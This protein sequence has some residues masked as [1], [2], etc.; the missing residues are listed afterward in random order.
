MGT[1]GRTTMLKTRVTDI[2]T[3]ADKHPFG[4]LATPLLGISVLYGG[5]AHLRRRLYALGTLKNRR[6]PCPVISVGNLTL[7]GTGKT[8]MVIH[9]AERILA[10]GYRP[11]I[12]SRG[13]KGLA[14]KRGAVV[15]DGRSLLCDAR[16]AGD[17]PYLMAALLPTVPVAVGRNRYRIGMDAVRRF[18]PDMVILD[19]GFQHLQLARDFNMLLLDARRPYGNGYIFPRGTLREPA[20]SLHSADAVV[21]TRSGQNRGGECSDLIRRVQPRP[22]F[23]S[24]HNSVV[25]LLLGAGQPIAG[26]TS[27]QRPDF[28]LKGK[29]VFA[30]TGLARNDAFFHALKGLGAGLQGTKGFDDH[31]AFT[32]GDLHRIAMDAER[33]GATCLV[34][35]DKD[36]VRLPRGIRLPLEL[37]VMG[38]RMDFGEQRKVWQTYIERVVK[39]LA[40]R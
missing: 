9:L 29:R 30:F 6:L 25:R 16:Q 8:P 3:R 5:L 12:L 13:Y 32:D 38:V 1:S 14:E 31:H 27:G 24:D 7:G 40:K 18:H 11:V 23:L 39:K 33:A 37:I 4:S 10:M 34:T 20:T 21:L 2:M 17:E 19:D 15:S 28:D 35:T 36:F 26:M 22:V